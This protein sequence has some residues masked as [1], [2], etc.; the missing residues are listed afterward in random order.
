MPH[1]QRAGTVTGVAVN[2]AA[3][4]AVMVQPYMPSVSLAI[5]GQ[6]RVPPDCFTLSRD[7][8]CTLPAGHRVG[9]VGAGGERAV[10]LPHM[11]GS[12]VFAPRG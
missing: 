11:G 10:P 5:R 4:L 1:R 9:A 8:P 6:L 3:L 12:G 2:V 7:F